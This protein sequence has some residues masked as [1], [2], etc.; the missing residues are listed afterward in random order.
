MLERIVGG[1]DEIVPMKELRAQVCGPIVHPFP[2]FR[3]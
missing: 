3:D 1:E 2:Q